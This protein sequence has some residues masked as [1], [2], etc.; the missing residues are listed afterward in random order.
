MIAKNNLIKKLIGM[1]IFQTAIILF[2][3]S[4]G[5]KEGATI[6]IYLPEH[7]PH[8]A[9]LGTES[10]ATDSL[11]SGPQVLDSSFV[12]GY[13]NP[14]PHV[15]MLTAIVVG[16]ATLGL[17]LSVCLRIYRAYGTAEEDELL[18]KLEREDARSSTGRN[19]RGQEDGA[20]PANQ[21]KVVNLNARRPLRNPKRATRRQDLFRLVQKTNLG[22][23]QRDH[24]KTIIQKAQ[25]QSVLAGLDSP[26]P[27]NPGGQ[28]LM[29]DH[30]VWVVLFPLFGAVAC[31]LAGTW[32]KKIC[33]PVSVLSMLA[34]VWASI[35]T[36]L[37]AIQS[38]AHEVSYI[39][40][41]GVLIFFLGSWDRISGRSSWC[42]N[43][44]GGYRSWFDCNLV[45]KVPVQRETSGKEPMYY[46]LFLLQ[47][48]GLAGIALTGD[49]FNLYVL[50]EVAAL[51]GYGLIALGSNR[52]AAATFNYIILGTIGAS[53]ICSGWIF[54]FEDR[55]LN[56]VGI[57]EVIEAHNLY[58]S[59]R[60]RLPSFWCCLV[61]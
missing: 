60:C 6:P 51:T 33:Y 23:Q 47:I 25:N 59:L 50:I 37:Q 27:A 48:A 15:L 46:G 8:G 1:S 57:R 12:P 39:L 58:D 7:D 56:M 38:P 61:S 3:V 44:T 32:S 45:P 11:A 55:H 30:I 24:R 35:H 31:A 53:Y 49:A 5:V 9:H 22:I 34:S 13:T 40:V 10:N 20:R 41:V 36:L 18:E 26:L 21:P 2:Y 16:V 52:A 28:V 19:R 42:F 54:V 17:A 29:S 14:L 4:I 43:Y